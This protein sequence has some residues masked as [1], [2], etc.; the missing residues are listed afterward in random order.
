MQVFIK[1]CRAWQCPSA[2]YT[3]IFDPLAL[4]YSTEKQCASSTLSFAVLW[5]RK[6]GFDTSVAPDPC[7]GEVAERRAV[8]GC[9]AASLSDRFL[10]STPEM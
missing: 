9:S 3:C 10:I 8:P 7:G 4:V 5:S 1:T 6:T 2:R